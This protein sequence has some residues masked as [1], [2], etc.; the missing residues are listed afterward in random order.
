MGVIIESCKSTVKCCDSDDE[1]GYKKRRYSDY[2]PSETESDG[3]NGEEDNNAQIEEP[4]EDKKIESI[5]NIKV[6]TN[7][8]FMQRHQSP[9]QFYEELEE[10]GSGFY[11][12][13]KKVR[14]KKN[15]DIFYKEKEHHLLMKLKF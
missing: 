6:D 13:V 4:K 5:E 1:A 14:L 8:L 11:G 7:N 15:P 2:V 10:L 3:E 12:V 9:W